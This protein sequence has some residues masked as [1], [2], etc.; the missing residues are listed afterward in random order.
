[1]VSVLKI[2]DTYDKG[3]EKGYCQA[4]RGG[5]NPGY[6]SQDEHE[7]RRDHSDNNY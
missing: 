5:Y 4:D 2:D 6:G 7:I 1:M 3:S